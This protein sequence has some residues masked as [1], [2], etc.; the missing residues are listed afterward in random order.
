MRNIL[1]ENGCDLEPKRGEESWD[2][3]N[4]MHAKTLWACDFFS[5]KAWTLGGLV[6][7]SSSS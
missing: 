1:L 2:E 4:K 6:S 3:F 5:K 7:N